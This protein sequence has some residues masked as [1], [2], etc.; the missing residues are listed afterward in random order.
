MSKPRQRPELGQTELIERL[1]LA[2]ANEAAAVEFLEA[3]RWGNEPYC[4]H[5]GAVG[6]CY[7]MTDRNTGE[8][9]KRFLWKCRDCSKMYTVRTGT[10]YAESL[11][12]LHKWCRALWE[13]ASAKNGCSA[14]ELSR[15][16]E[17][18]VG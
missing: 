15:S 1:P 6:N 5:C 7:K 3:E 2:C 10:V 9:N 12:P 16:E 4:P 11:I 17:R 13:C 8:R 14:L 18:R